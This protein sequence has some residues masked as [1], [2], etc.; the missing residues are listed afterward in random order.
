MVG[1]VGS[2][3]KPGVSPPAGGRLCSKVLCGCLKGREV[4]SAGRL[5][6][7]DG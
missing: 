7:S 6:A 4:L 1:P 2:S 5:G 3:G